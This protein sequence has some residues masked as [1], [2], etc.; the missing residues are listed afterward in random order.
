MKNKYGIREKPG[1]TYITDTRHK[2]WNINTHPHM[3]LSSCGAETIYIN[4]TLPVD[5]SQSPPYYTVISVSNS[6]LEKICDHRNN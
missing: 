2:K 5:F 4:S 3:A 6:R 1:L